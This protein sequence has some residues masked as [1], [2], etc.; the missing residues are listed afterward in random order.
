MTA[1]LEHPGIVPIYG[2]GVTD[3][4]RPFYAMR[5]VRGE[6]LKRAV[7]RFHDR[8]VAGD[9]SARS[10]AFRDLLRRFID[11]CNTIA[12]AHDRGVLHRDLKPSN[13]L[14]GRFGET[15]VIDWG[16]AKLVGPVA[17]DLALDEPAAPLRPIDRPTYET[18]VGDAIG[19]PSYMSPEQADGRSDSA[20]TACD[21]YGLGATLYTILS[22]K[23][24]REGGDVRRVLDA[25]RSGAFPPPRAVNRD[26]PPALE[27]V[28]LKAMARRPDDR[29]RSARALA[30][31]VE[32]WLAG[33]PVSAWR[34]PW[35][36]RLRRRLARHRTAA[37]A[38]AAALVVAV[39]AGGYVAHGA[40]IRAAERR[41]RAE[42]WV[43][44]LEAAETRQ[45]PQIL[46]QLRPDRPWVDPLLAHRTGHPT[47]DPKAR[48]HLALA[49]AANDPGQ[50]DWLSDRLLVA[51]PDQ[52][53][54]I[55][56][57]LGGHRDALLPRL[58]RVLEDPE[59]DPARRFRAACALALYDPPASDATLARWE[60]YAGLIVDAA[61]EAVLE[62]PGH[63]E[64]LVQTL[65]PL[66][67]VLFL[68][69]MTH[70]RRRQGTQAYRR[71]SAAANFLGEYADRAD[72]MVELLRHAGPQEFDGFL[73]KLGDGPEPALRAL[74]AAAREAGL[75]EDDPPDPS[76]AAPDPAITR[77]VEQAH[78]IVG[79]RFALCQTMPLDD[80]VE[81][82]EAL[83]RAG[84]RPIRA[85]P[86]A[87]RGDPAGRPDVLVAAVWA[88]DG[89]PW[90]MAHGV[91]AGTIA[92]R[93]GTWRREGYQPVDIAGYPH[94][95]ERRF[96]LLYHRGGPRG[97]IEYDI[98]KSELQ[99][100][101]A[102]LIADRWYPVTIQGDDPAGPDG[103]AEGSYNLVARKSGR[104]I[105]GWA[106][107]VASNAFVNRPIDIVIEK[108]IFKYYQFTVITW[109][110]G[111]GSSALSFGLPPDGHRLHGRVLA[112]LGFRP[113]AI[114]AALPGGRTEP[115]TA[116]IWRRPRSTA[117]AAPV[118]GPDDP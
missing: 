76:W 36:A 59:A 84:Y 98:P 17:D 113:V 1:R 14:L 97:K 81:V 40:R 67:R 15:V 24:P 112:A 19:S 104:W 89:Q 35:P 45:L 4:G 117:V 7:E 58:R 39:L 51:D 114:S 60:P 26:V 9:P 33:E 56:T 77:R 115:V 80:F 71:R 116:S 57:I 109:D 43:R 72:E 11:V 95:R 25:A 38:A 63:F 21:I 82:A 53:R 50:V 91:G 108:D 101:V 31:D 44:T 55:C 42:G 106:H 111:P 118:A 41:S 110:G 69:L 8:A 68:R 103:R 30:E 96:L 94:G 66:R 65:R 12:Y 13:I 88:R 99:D 86:Y 3:R 93:D 18:M 22:G 100:R 74:A 32:R 73:A 48:L 2:Q 105:R 16:L 79:D 87:G 46:E 92:A 70:Y 64:P 54:V 52:L 62:N 37:G 107:G 102:R 29:Y 90:R 20:G 27:A 49:G 61:L 6:S 78:G 5:F 28:C 23:P 47:L 34:E 75:V 83:R 85:R 10:L